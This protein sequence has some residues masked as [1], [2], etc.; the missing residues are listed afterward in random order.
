MTVYKQGGVK[1]QHPVTLLV[2]VITDP[3][4]VNW[5]NLTKRD[6][7][8]TCTAKSYNVYQTHT[9]TKVW[10]SYSLSYRYKAILKLDNSFIWIVFLIRCLLLLFSFSY[11]YP[12]KWGR[13]SSPQDCII[14]TYIHNNHALSPKGYQRHLRHFSQTPTL[15]ANCLA[16]SNTADLTS[17]KSIAVWS[18]SISGVNAVIPLV[19]FYDVHGRK[20][21]ILLFCPGHQTR[22]VLVLC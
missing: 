19:A 9:N 1:L 21:K 11:F 3:C 6:F 15:Y 5:N 16:M 8:F 12:T 22:L 10:Q 17:G 7:L 18:Q 14:H 20:R 2:I 13:Y 4:C